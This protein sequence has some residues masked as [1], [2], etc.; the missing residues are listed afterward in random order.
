MTQRIR[1]SIT[2]SKGLPVIEVCLLF[3]A[4]PLMPASTTTLRNS[5]YQGGLSVFATTAA[6]WVFV[7]VTLGAFT[8]TI[9]AGMAF[10]DWPLSNGSVNPDGW[11]TEIEKFAE[12]SHRL[13]GT[14]MGLIAIGLAVWLFIDPAKKIGSDLS[15]PAREVK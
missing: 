6:V 15:H 2:L 1:R 8:T 3:A 7:L 10:A 14:T 12:H 11:L 5:A 4:F 13:S 9:G